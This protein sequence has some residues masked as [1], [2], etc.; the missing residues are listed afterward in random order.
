MLHGFQ[1]AITK[2][3]DRDS[4]RVEIRLAGFLSQFAECALGRMPVLGLAAAEEFLAAARDT[5]IVRA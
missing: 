3:G 1:Q 2:L 4:S 5:R